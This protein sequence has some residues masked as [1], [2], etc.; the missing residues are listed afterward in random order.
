MAFRILCVPMM[1]QMFH[2]NA[3]AYMKSLNLVKGFFSLKFELM[4]AS[5]NDVHIMAYHK[6]L[7]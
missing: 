4:F 1:D 5:F 6:L 2:K 7:V 3:Y